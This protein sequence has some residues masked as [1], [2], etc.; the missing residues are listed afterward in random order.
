MAAVSIV[1]KYHSL[2]KS[3]FPVVRLTLI[4]KLIQFQNFSGVNILKNK[5]LARTWSLELRKTSI[6][7][8]RIHPK[9]RHNVRIN[10]AIV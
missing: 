7:Y 1:S 5:S 10:F 2:I 9:F 6:N 4:N 8:R 3:N